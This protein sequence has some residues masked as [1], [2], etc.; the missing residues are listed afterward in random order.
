MPPSIS[1]FESAYKNGYNYGV[2]VCHDGTVYK[3]SC[4]IMPDKALYD[5]LIFSFTGLGYS[6][7]TAE[8]MALDEMEYRGILEIREVN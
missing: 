1:D 6:E 5:A 8:R 2:V 7:F 3:Y 4:S